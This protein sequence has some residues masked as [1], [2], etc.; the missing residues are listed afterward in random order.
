MAAEAGAA[1]RLDRFLWHVRIVKTRSA[2][3]ALAGSGH[4]R[5]D[6]RAVDRPA[7]PVRLGN[8]LTFV[9]A[10]GS[11]RVIRVEALPVRRGPPAEARGCYVELADANVSQQA[12]GD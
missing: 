10:G 6:G 5:I 7:A 2:A 4:L 12:P 3:Q 9:G 1:M 8:I 11:V